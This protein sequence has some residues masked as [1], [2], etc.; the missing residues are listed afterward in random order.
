MNYAE[1]RL[2]RRSRHAGADSSSPLEKD[3]NQA[4]KYLS[5]DEQSMKTKY[6]GHELAGRTLRDAGLSPQATYHYAMAWISACSLD[7]EDEGDCIFNDE[8]ELE[9]E[10]AVGDYAQMAE[11]AGFPEVAVITLLFHMNGGEFKMEGEEKEKWQHMGNVGNI[12]AEDGTDRFN[13]N[14]GCGLSECGASDC[15]IP[16]QI[17]SSSLYRDI[18]GDFND[19]E[20]HLNDSNRRE[21]SLAADILDA[22]EKATRKKNPI[23]MKPK[24]PSDI[25]LSL[26]FWSNKSIRPLSHLLQILLLKILYSAPVGSSFLVLACEGIRHLSR[27][28]PLSSK[29]GREMAQSHKSHWAYYVLIHKVVLGADRVKM[30]RR[31]VIPYH[32]PVWDIVNTL[33]QR[34]FSDEV[35][36]SD[37]QDAAQDCSQSL[38]THLESASKVLS[39][40]ICENRQKIQHPILRCL[41]Q[42]SCSKTIYA[43]GDSH[44]LSIGWQTLHIKNDEFNLNRIIRPC[45]TTGLKAWHTREGTQFFTKYNLDCCLE[46]L[47]KTCRSIILSAGEIDCREGIGG[48]LLEGLNN[49][50]DDAVRNTVKEYIHAIRNLS[51]KYNLQVL[52]L[53]V[54]PHAYRSVKKGKSLGRGLRRQR[55]LLWNETLRELCAIRASQNENGQ[56]FLLDYEPGLR[57]KNE[58][59]PVGFVLNK[60]YNADFTHMNSSFL[61]LLEKALVECNC[62]LSLL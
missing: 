41:P 60:Y 52:L 57:E 21:E 25:P 3:L 9:R 11:L 14:C 15:F 62:D 45:P 37:C 27:S 48:D 12:F 8:F 19:L 18:L 43:I 61:P 28:L 40:R 30:H 34:K 55:M 58:E 51:C 38:A 22:V 47:P 35:H 39:T 20:S 10:K 33:D 13:L 1:D 24:T 32:V 6:K 46:R 53:P 54:A 59:S 26:R 42:Q 5:A 4:H 23:V 49:D 44:V 31:K 50:C 56:V 29:L 17:H 36:D 7:D 2:D 16:S